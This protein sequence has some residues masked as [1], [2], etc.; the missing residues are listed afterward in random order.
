[1]PDDLLR[2]AAYREI[3]LADEND[4]VWILSVRPDGQLT[5]A[6]F[7]DGEPVRFALELSISREAI[8]SAMADMLESFNEPVDLDS[9][10]ERI[11]SYRAR[12]DNPNLSPSAQATYAMLIKHVERE[13]SRE[14]S[15]IERKNAALDHV[16]DRRDDGN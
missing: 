7:P 9:L 1:M 15:R 13:L 6:K 5:T 12:L 4:Q 10:R 3:A 14:L 16:L 2:P 8:Q 11:A